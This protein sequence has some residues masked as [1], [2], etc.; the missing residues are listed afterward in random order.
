MKS[1]KYVK[2]SLLLALLLFV[3]FIIVNLGS[4]N[5]KKPE[6]PEAVSVSDK[7][8]TVLSESSIFE[9][10]KTEMGRKI[11]KISAERFEGYVDGKQKLINVNLVFFGER[12]GNIAVSA[13]EAEYDP[14]NEN[15]WLRNNVNVN[16]AGGLELVTDKLDYNGGKSATTDREVQ[17]SK[18][19]YNG[20]A[21]GLFFDL[22]V[23]EL[24][25]SGNVVLN[26]S[27][28][29]LSGNKLEYS[30][31]GERAVLTES[32]EVVFPGQGV[33][34]CQK[35][36]AYFP[37]NILD[38]IFAEGNV[39]FQRMNG[40]DGLK[41]DRIDFFMDDD[42]KVPLSLIATGNTEVSFSNSETMEGYVLKTGEI[43]ADFRQ[44]KL[45]TIEGISA[46]SLTI[47]NGDGRISE[48]AFCNS[49]LAF[50][51]GDEKEFFR[52][53]LDGNVR[54]KSEEF[55]SKSE[56]AIYYRDRNY[57]VLRKSVQI[58][59]DNYEIFSDRIRYDDVKKKLYAEGN[60][61]TK[62]TGSAT[63]ELPF[64][65][66]SPVY[67][68]ADSLEMMGREELAIFTGSV[69][70][71]QGRD[72]LLSD[73]LELDRKAG[74]VRGR[75]NV[76]T[77]ILKK[78]EALPMIITAEN[79]IYDQQAKVAHYFPEVNFSRKQFAL[80]CRSVKIFMAEGI[81]KMEMDGELK[82]SGE[83]R[84]AQ[85]EKGVYSVKDNSLLLSA[86]KSF[87]SITDRQS[88]ETVKGRILT[89][90]ADS[91]SIEILGGDPYG[92]TSSSSGTDIKGN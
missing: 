10:T 18:G 34:R 78:D 31:S 15:V 33:L 38:K 81:D 84:T 21:Q 80:S 6:P 66:D 14:L 87:V 11:F 64:S 69:N 74:E 47:T 56:E 46:S 67:I 25:L 70:A 3:V 42:G 20:S 7:D 85:A 63:L 35:I 65:G 91:D 9:F 72:V 59:Y 92:R 27:N 61:K 16:G 24:V 52:L 68:S 39:S 30:M 57:V 79:L 2:I 1:V 13:G 49:F 62:I 77:R 53:S 75:G 32:P 60:V 19:D 26:G 45:N 44:G 76:T 37:N 17:F 29:S 36:E 43:S 83:R 73:R 12:G 51:N 22:E 4:K 41:A 71:R 50:Y 86:E 88:G 90:R 82:L 55:S 40:S 58:F 5:E 54:I 89:Y 28:I 8:E 23:R 48:E